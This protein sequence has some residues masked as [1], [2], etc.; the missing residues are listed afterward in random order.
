MSEKR[1]PFGLAKESAEVKTVLAPVVGRKSVVPTGARRAF[2]QVVEGSAVA[3][4][5]E[6]PQ[7]PAGLVAGRSEEVDFTLNAPHASR[8]HA[9]F[10]YKNGQLMVEDL[11]SANGTQVNDASIE[12]ATPLKGGDLIYV[13]G[14]TLEV[15]VEGDTPRPKQLTAPPEGATVVDGM[16]GLAI[17]SMTPD[18]PPDVPD[19]LSRHGQYATAPEG[20]PP[21][22][23]QDTERPPEDTS[24]ALVLSR[25]QERGMSAP[26]ARAQPPARPG[27]SPPASRSQQRPAARPAS[28]SQRAVPASGARRGKLPPGARAAL[29]RMGSDFGRP[30]DSL[31]TPL[32][33]ASPPSFDDFDEPS[34]ANRLEPPSRVRGAARPEQ[35]TVEEPQEGLAAPRRGI[36]IA[37]CAILLGVMGV[38]LFVPAGKPKK[39]P[40]PPIEEA[41]ERRPDPPPTGAAGASGGTVV[42]PAEAVAE[43][44]APYEPSLPPPKPDQLKQAVEA[45]E[46]SNYPLALRHFTILR[47]ASPGDPALE[48]MV[49]LVGR[50]A[51]LVQPGSPR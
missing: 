14:V 25:P 28:A 4:R 19:H 24:R 30:E 1:R 3:D 41:R 46:G 23:P 36:V 45:F 29:D 39:A 27:P 50:R 8:R 9:R 48:F 20:L 31:Y 21:Y 32:P 47:D 22:P 13:A 7:S 10:F 44:D 33:P 42:A 17:R 49:R 2:L 37:C 35:P 43:S 12:M 16:A 34:L 18:P 5:I 15:L 6:I 38:I 26:P 51:E 11:G 40:S